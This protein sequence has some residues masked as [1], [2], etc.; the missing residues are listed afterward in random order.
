L[1]TKDN[2][3][4]KKQITLQ[5]NRE[6]RRANLPRPY[7]DPEVHQ[8]NLAL[9]LASDPRRKSN[10]ELFLKSSKSMLVEHLPIKL[11]V[12]N[13]SRCNFRCTM[14][15]VSDWGPSYQRAQDMS[16][17][18][19]KNLVDEQYGL[20]ELKLQGMGEPLLARE[21]FFKMVRYARSKHIWVRTTTNASL[22]HFHD[23]YKHLIDSGINEVQISFDGATKKTFE[24]IRIGSSFDLVVK[25]CKLINDYCNDQGLLRTR[26]WVVVQQGN[27]DQIPDF[28]RLASEMGF[29]RLTFSLELTDWG[30]ERWSGV[31][32]KVTAEDDVSPESAAAAIEQGLGIGVE[33]TFWD[34]T[35]KYRTDSP[36]SL[37]RWPFERAYVSSDM[38]IVPCCTIANPDVSDLGVARQLAKAWNNETYQEFRKSHLEGRIPE[39]CK[40][41]YVNESLDI[42]AEVG[43]HG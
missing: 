43:S 41:C 27:V 15:Q 29:K 24:K 19:F 12:E 32:Q 3:N 4:S 23:N 42:S 9:A 17:D 38:R 1:E 16:F 14:C 10:Y 21:E 40:L 18:D 5:Q 34:I 11:D 26:M 30:Q 20:V 22:L 25:N 39:P 36:E 13:V 33:V 37:C 31:N 28:V 35:D 8:R 7:P 2:H 6:Y